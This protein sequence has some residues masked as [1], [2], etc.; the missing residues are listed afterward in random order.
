MNLITGGKKLSIATISFE[1]FLSGGFHSRVATTPCGLLSELRFSG[2]I[3]CAIK[4]KDCTV[5]RTADGLQ[6]FSSLNLAVPAYQL[7]TD[8]QEDSMRRLPGRMCCG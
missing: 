3:F 7:V 2:L 1:E 4:W 6:L 8:R 5:C